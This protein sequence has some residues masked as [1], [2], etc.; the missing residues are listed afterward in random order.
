MVRILSRAAL[1]QCA[2][3]KHPHTLTHMRSSAVDSLLLRQGISYDQSQSC[4]SPGVF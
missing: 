3:H 1:G 4:V 2:S